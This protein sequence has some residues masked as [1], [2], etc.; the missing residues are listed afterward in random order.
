MLYWLN[1]RRCGAEV[2]NR[3]LANLV[4]A[5]ASDRTIPSSRLIDLVDPFVAKRYRADRWG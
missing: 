1:G 3:P 4:R 2:R 5:S